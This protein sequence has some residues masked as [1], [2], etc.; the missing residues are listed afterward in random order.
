MSRKKKTLLLIAVALL[1]IQFIQPAR[2]T[3]GQVLSTDFVMMY[4]PP[5]QI[6]SILQNACYD[7]HSNN[8]RYPWYANVQ[9][10]AWLMSSHIKNGKEK[11][12]MS[13]FGNLS[14]RKQ[15]SKLKEISN[16]IKDDEMPI[17]SYK[18]MHADA[19]LSKDE[20]DLLMKW[21]QTKA[22]SLSASF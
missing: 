4:K 16:Q 13:E 19:R 14:I 3:S 9:P 18:L 17:A 10:M 7:C 11:L 20:K 5:Q 21:L 2:N 22:A 6:Q 12:N 1:V 15:I 8:T